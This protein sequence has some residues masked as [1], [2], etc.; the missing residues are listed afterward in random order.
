MVPAPKEDHRELRRVTCPKWA[1]VPWA[2]SSAPQEAWTCWMGILCC[3]VRGEGLGQ[4]RCS[5]TS[6]D[7]SLLPS[8]PGRATLG[9]DISQLWIPWAT[10][11]ILHTMPLCLIKGDH[12][13]QALGRQDSPQHR[14]C[15]GLSALLGAPTPP[16]AQ[17][18]AS[19]AP[20]QGKIEG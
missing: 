18:G 12:G 10:P 5:G 1:S 2:L 6:S 9:G 14:T 7:L 15:P 4:G 11:L 13:T 3:F 8:V 16:A 20:E 17:V 19:S